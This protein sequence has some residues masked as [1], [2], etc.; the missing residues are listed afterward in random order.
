MVTGRVVSGDGKP[1]QGVNVTVKSSTV[2]TTTDSDGKYK[3]SAPDA[4]GTQLQFSF[5]GYRSIEKTMNAFS[6]INIV[7]YEEVSELSQVVV[8]ATTFHS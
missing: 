3:I 8:S 4:Q 2:G 5:I 1:L 7:M 6:E